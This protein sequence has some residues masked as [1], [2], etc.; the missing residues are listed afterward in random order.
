M[1]GVRVEGLWRWVGDGW[2]K[3]PPG[4]EVS[5]IF[6]VDWRLLITQLLIWTVNVAVKSPIARSYSGDGENGR[7][8]SRY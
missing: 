3:Q 5:D 8:E 6:H 4:A 2:V 1:Q 7:S